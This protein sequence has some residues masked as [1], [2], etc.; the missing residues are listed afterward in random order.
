MRGDL[1]PQDD[2][3]HLRMVSAER[4]EYRSGRPLR[5]PQP[6]MQDYRP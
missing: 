5:E 4:E 1:E 6:D 3:N 2:G